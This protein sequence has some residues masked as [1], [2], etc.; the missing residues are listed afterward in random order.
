MD[1]KS[2]WKG[3][4]NGLLTVIEVL[5]DSETWVDCVCEC[6]GR[7]YMRAQ[8]FKRAINP[9]CGCL[10]KASGMVNTPTYHSWAGM[11]QRCLNPDHSAYENYGGR[12]IKVCDRWMS[13]ENFLADMGERPKGKEL[14]RKDTNGHYD[15]SNCRWVK[16]IDN[17]INRRCTRKLTVNGVTRTWVEW[18][19]LAGISRGALKMRLKRGWSPEQAVGLQKRS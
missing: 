6:G 1:I 11:K 15:S 3:Q 17:I 13:F 4:K 12:G 9:S 14:D 2:R 7:K 10:I 16:R 18:A 5:R 8:T 19:D